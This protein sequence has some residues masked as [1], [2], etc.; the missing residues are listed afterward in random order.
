MRWQTRVTDRLNHR[1]VAKGVIIVPIRWVPQD[2][3]SAPADPAESETE[4]EVGAG[5]CGQ[6]VVPGEGGVGVLKGEFVKHVRGHGE[7]GGE[8]VEDGMV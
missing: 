6:G 7:S 2:E 5:L 8:A 4:R 1:I 3:R